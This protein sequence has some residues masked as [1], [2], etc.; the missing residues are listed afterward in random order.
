M[1]A[2]ERSRKT[3]VEKAFEGVD[4]FEIEEAWKNFTLGLKVPR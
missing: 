2:E 1:A 4:Y 3:A